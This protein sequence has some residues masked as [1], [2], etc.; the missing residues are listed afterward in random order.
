M[1]TPEPATEAGELCVFQ[2]ICA[3][4][5]RCSNEAVRGAAVE[6]RKRLHGFPA[7]DVEVTALH[8]LCILQRMDGHLNSVRGF[9]SVTLSELKQCT[10]S[11]KTL[12]GSFCISPAL[13]RVAIKEL[14]VSY[15]NEETS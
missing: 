14:G 3:E 15:H 13:D 9:M 11:R 10:C 8:C 4:N 1:I 7:E 2:L 12:V 5:C 6:N